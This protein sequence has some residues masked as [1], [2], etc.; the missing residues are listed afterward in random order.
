MR[1]VLDAVL[2]QR[3]CVCGLEQGGAPVCPECAVDLPHVRNA[4]CRVCA[5]PLP[6]GG[7][8]GQCLKRPP[9]FDASQALFDYRFPLDG[10]VQALKYR[11]RFSLGGFF[12]EEMMAAM[13]P[14]ELD[15]ILPM[16]LHPARL[17]ER[18]FNQAVEIARPL[19]R[20]AG[21]PLV[22]RGV[23]RV[24]ATPKL[25][26]LSRQER[27]AALR[28]AF[29]CRSDVNGMRVAV[30]DDVMTSGAS[31]DELARCLKRSGAAWVEN[32]VVART[33]PPG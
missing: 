27:R 31:L 25:E 18:G 17:A 32:L 16:P 1:A 29:V 3:C 24:R 23:A 13:F 7:V 5:Q 4:R 19:A 11:Q 26:G 2:P 21:L 22:L 9:A 33:P 14:R 28:G 20:L 30:V 12:A 15:L 10:L 6:A 8:C